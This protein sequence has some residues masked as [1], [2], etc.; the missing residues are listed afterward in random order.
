MWDIFTYIVSDFIKDL[1]KGE[2]EKFA[3]GAKWV[4]DFIIFPLPSFSSTIYNMGH[5][6]QDVLKG[7]QGQQK[8]AR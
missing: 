5:L 1:L 8:L 4:K 7:Q 6:L 2:S 3:R